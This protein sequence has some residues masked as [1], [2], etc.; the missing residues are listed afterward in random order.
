MYATEVSALAIHHLAYLYLIS[1]IPSFPLLAMFVIVSQS[2]GGL[3][4]GLVFTVGHNAMEVFTEDEMRKLDYVRLQVATTRDVT[5][6]WFTDWFCGGLNYQ[7]EHHIWPTIPRHN[8]PK[9]AELL[10]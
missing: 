7:V 9:A 6:H 1:Y 4:I 2:L 10:T 8:L 3:F 5:P